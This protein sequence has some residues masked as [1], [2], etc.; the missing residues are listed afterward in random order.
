M[1]RCDM[2]LLYA[3]LHSTSRNTREIHINCPWK[4]SLIE[5]RSDMR[6][7]CLVAS[8]KLRVFANIYYI[9][10]LVVSAFRLI[11]NDIMYKWKAQ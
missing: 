5:I 10:A 7:F 11:C 2:H 6:N 4:T 8:E 1:R 9:S 3:K